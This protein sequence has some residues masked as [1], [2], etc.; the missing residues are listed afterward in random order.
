M[1]HKMYCHVTTY[2]VVSL[3]VVSY[4]LH[5]FK[6]NPYCVKIEFAKPT[7]DVILYDRLA[8]HVSANAARGRFMR[9]T[10]TVE[11]L[12]IRAAIELRAGKEESARQ[13]IAEKQ[14]IMRALERS[15]K[16][17]EIL[18]ELS[19]K[20]G[21]VCPTLFLLWHIANMYSELNLWIFRE[22]R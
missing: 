20:L 11:N 15:K 3:L 10:E 1:E 17:A 2:G 6:E 12:G 4:M 8:L 5:W 19:N 22:Q 9:L 14:K 16:R 18:E 21:E 13:L 7:F